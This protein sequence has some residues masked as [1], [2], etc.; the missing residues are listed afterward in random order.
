MVR[1]LPESDQATRKHGRNN[2]LM[3]YLLTFYF[4]NVV[5]LTNFHRFRNFANLGDARGEKHTMY[6]LW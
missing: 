2:I 3:F 1:L 5:T 4:I 6:C